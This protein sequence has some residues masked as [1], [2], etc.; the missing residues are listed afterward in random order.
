MKFIKQKK[1]AAAAAS[2]PPLSTSINSDNDALAMSYNDPPTREGVA[3]SSADN[4]DELTEDEAQKARK[5]SS[6]TSFISPAERKRRQQEKIDALNK[7]K[8]QDS[9]SSQKQQK[10]PPAAS[11]AAAVED[12]KSE[13]SMTDSEKQR[14]EVVQRTSFISPME[15]K[16]RALERQKSLQAEEE[17]KNSNNNND[18]QQED[19]GD[20]VTKTSSVSSSIAKFNQ[21]F[22]KK[23]TKRSFNESL[24][25]KADA[26]LHK[27]EPTSSDE[28]GA[29]LLSADVPPTLSDI[30]AAVSAPSAQDPERTVL[31]E[32]L[33]SSTS[34]LVSASYPTPKE[35]D[36]EKAKRAAIQAV[37]KDTSLSPTEKNAK[38]QSIIRGNFEGPTEAAAVITPAVV[39]AASVT[40]KEEV[41]ESSSGVEEED[42]SSSG[43]YETSSGEEE[44]STGEYET[45][46]EEEEEEEVEGEDGEE[47]SS[48][49]YESSSGEEESTTVIEPVLE[50]V[51]ASVKAAPVVE[52]VKAAPEE[53]SSSGVEEE[54]EESDVVVESLKAEAVPE[55]TSVDQS[56]AGGS[57]YVSKSAAVAKEKSDLESKL[58]QEL[59]NHHALER[60]HEQRQAEF[61]AEQDRLHKAEAAD[62]ER[63]RLL[64]VERREEQRRLEEEQRLLEEE[65]LR[66]EMEQ[67]AAENERR[68]RLEEEGQR[69]LELVQRRLQQDKEKQRALAR[70]QEEQRQYEEQRRQLEEEQRRLE[71]ER[72]HQQI[73]DRQREQMLQLQEEQ[74]RLEEERIQFEEE[75]RRLR[76]ERVHEQVQNSRAVGNVD[77]TT[78][79]NTRVH[80]QVQ[81]SRAVGN[82]DSTTIRNTRPAPRS[83]PNKT[84]SSSLPGG[85]RS[86][87]PPLSRVAP[88]T[89]SSLQNTRY[90]GVDDDELN[91]RLD[92]YAMLSDYTIIVRRALP[93]PHAPDFEVDDAN[94][95]DFS[96]DAGNPKLD[97]YYVHKAMIAV[98]SRRSELL[99]RRI[100]EADSTTRPD[101]HSSDVNVH[102]TI[103]LE[104]AADAMGIV[105]DFLYYPDKPLEMNIHNAVPLVY[106]GKRYRIRALI[107]QSEEFVHSHLESTN[108]I[109]FLL[110]SYL[111]QLD[112]ILSRAIDVTAANLGATLDFNPIYQLPPELFRR[113]ILSKDLNC[114]SGLLSLIVY[115]Y[116]GEHHAEDIDV[117]YLREITKQRLMPEIDSKVALMLLKFY[118]DLIFADDENCDIMDVLVG[119]SLMQR[120]IA[121]AAKHWQGE[122][123]EPLMV[124][125]EFNE[126]ASP[127]KRRLPAHEPT[128]IHR[129]LPTKLQNYLLEK[130]II[131]AKNDFDSER[132]AKDAQQGEKQAEIEA[133]TKSCDAIVRELQNDLRESEKNKNKQNLKTHLDKIEAK[134]LEMEAEL[135]LQKQKAEAYK[136]ELKRFRRV[137]GIHNFGEVC[138]KDPTVVDKTKCTY[139]GNP[140]HHYPLH[141]R[142]DRPPTQMPGMTAEF[143]NLAKEN[144]YIYDDGHGG[145]LPVFYYVNTSASV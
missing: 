19:S 59:E 141:R 60:Q 99:G 6:F 5:Q 73:L 131:E 66:V 102:E 108:A 70:Q 23:D 29:S 94:A 110:D 62:A 58:D 144:G 38:M 39:T 49:E 80:E 71:A 88:V 129:A 101:G 138:K 51:V 119:D 34:S 56:T 50:P 137:P 142:G 114:D 16:K 127:M 45:T 30:E 72:E 28:Q 143:Q 81:A 53:T 84:I 4:D 121:V 90:D 65:R 122:V 47:T 79:S 13:I 67:Q 18:N 133:V 116:C 87:I 7:K 43:E 61:R 97:S 26:V 77:R 118:V 85:Q 91:W 86:R 124:D 41:E 78:T 11:S 93:G 106:L 14:V 132:A 76:E 120:C 48:G 113:I 128:A 20:V 63:L 115:S 22:G 136:Q 125:S 3:K 8:E 83:S 74:R 40:L 134:M 92:S 25:K 24:T 100:R 35:S 109:H 117:E 15:R 46:S 32:S 103:M 52:P 95:I 75:Q 2:Q 105:L 123:Y 9:G 17:A 33:A 64:E 31:S 98:G 1:A 112:D 21:T 96:M 36:R 54:E 68:R 89:S 27:K 37:M 130:C 55:D 82:A 140:D 107:E 10:S 69:A 139:S 126:S 135:E 145:L 57:G 42:D 44:S 111:Y 104:S 12:E